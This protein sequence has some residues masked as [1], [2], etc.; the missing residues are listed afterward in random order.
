MLVTEGPDATGWPYD[1]FMRWL[2]A[3]V[4]IACPIRCI[5]WRVG[6]RPSLPPGAPDLR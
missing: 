3:G 2:V 6:L 5:V 4:A 1:Q